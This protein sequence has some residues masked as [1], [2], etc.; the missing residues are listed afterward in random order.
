MDIRLIPSKMLLFKASPN[1]VVV[2]C[3]WMGLFR[4]QIGTYEER[5]EV[6]WYGSE[7]VVDVWLQK[8]L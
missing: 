1:N 2:G 3:G 5:G 7:K 6:P 8:L 4:L